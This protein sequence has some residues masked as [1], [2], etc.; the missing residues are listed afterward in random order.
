[1]TYGYL[2]VSHEN[3]TVENQ[4]FEITNFCKKNNLKIDEWIEETVSGIKE[5]NKRKLGNLL[6]KLQ[7]DDL[8]LCTEISRLGRSL[9]MVMSILNDCLKRGIR[10]WTI[11]DNYRLG[12]DISSM[13]IAFAF[14]LSAQIE[15]QLISQ[16]VKQALNRLRDEGV[17]IGR[18]RGEVNKVTKLK[19]NEKKI[20]DMLMQGIPKYKIAKECGVHRSSL[21]RFLLKLESNKPSIKKKQEEILAKKKKIIIKLFKEGKTLNDIAHRLSVNNNRLKNFC[22][23][24]LKIE[25]R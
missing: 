20:K 15:R 7:K 19:S 5:V 22:R 16:R 21:R 14:S 2:R 9:L 8:L 4:R 18:P 6:D 13:V 17:F 23:K 11:K 12:D 25:I 10:I 24:E 1:M 3:S